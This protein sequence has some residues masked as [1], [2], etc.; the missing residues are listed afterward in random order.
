M[1]LKKT[2][3]FVVVLAAVLAWIFFFELPKSREKERGDLLF[4][5]AKESQLQTIQIAKQDRLVTL[6]NKLYEP[7]PKPEE[8]RE[9]ESRSPSE[10]ELPNLPAVPLD[11]SAVQS[12]VSALLGLKLDNAIPPEEQDKD[13]SVYGL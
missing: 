5:E 13:L 6:R 12:L 10:W 4:K 9:D 3:M 8:K 7:T 11:S 2:M 1:S